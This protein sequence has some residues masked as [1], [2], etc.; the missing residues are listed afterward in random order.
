M[1]ADT[2]EYAELKTGKRSEGIIFST[3]TFT[4]K[5]KLGLSAF[6][7]GLILEAFGYMPNLS[8]SVRSLNGI[9]L[10]LTLIP[11]LGSILTVIPLFFYKLSDD[12]HK[13][14]VEKLGE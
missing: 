5:L 2:V 11:A 9:Y 8:Q 6:F 3:L 1:L 13:R 7:V 10:M 14:I 12:E 4:G